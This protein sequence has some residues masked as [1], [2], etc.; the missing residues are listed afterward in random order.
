MI[1]SWKLRRTRGPMGDVFPNAAHF[2]EEGNHPDKK[3]FCVTFR[4]GET[5][6]SE[7][8]GSKSDML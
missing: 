3:P 5:S 7:I 8:Y 2:V 4:S 1:K 6:L